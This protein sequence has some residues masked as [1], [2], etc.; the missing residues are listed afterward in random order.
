ML[1]IDTITLL[2]IGANVLISSK[3]FQDYSFF[4]KYKFN[5]G[6]IRRGEFIRYL[7]S[8]FLHADWT[9]LLVNMLTL[10]FFAGAI[11]ANMGP[12]IF[13]VIYFGS[14]LLGNFLSYAFHKNEY[15]YSAIG[16]SGAVSGIVFAFVLLYPDQNLYLY[17]ALPIKAW[18]F[19]IAYL[20][21]SIYGMRKQLGNIGHDAHFGGA[22]AGY[23][24]TLLFN[25]YL[26]TSQT[27]IVLLLAIPI[28][29]LF[30]LLRT[31]KN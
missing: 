11:I 31:N 8:G 14:L 21:F 26:L 25:P 15:H 13:L 5:I 19:G 7:S 12:L 24:L 9:H 22:A 10:Y 3:G 6:G 23:G 18:I 17:F 20:V 2:L 30:I 29:A 1:G 27:E 4:E 28:V 16:A